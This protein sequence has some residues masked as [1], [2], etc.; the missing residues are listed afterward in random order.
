[1]YAARTK[2]CVPHP[3]EIHRSVCNSFT[4]QV[5]FALELI[6]ATYELVPA[7]ARVGP[8]QRYLTSLTGEQPYGVV[9]TDGYAALNPHHA[10]PT[11]ITERGDSIW[12][13]HT[14]V[15][16]VDLPRLGG[17]DKSVDQTLAT[18]HSVEIQLSWGEAVQIRVVN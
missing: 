17:F 13:S 1:M 15:R 5:L 6:G 16:C 4:V 3:I 14:I 2:I 8:S 7:S 10:I 11:L 12:E 9:G 18:T